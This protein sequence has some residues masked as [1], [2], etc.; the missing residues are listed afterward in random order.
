MAAMD[1]LPRGVPFPSITCLGS[2]L[3]FMFCLPIIRCYSFIW[4]PSC[5][6]NV[7]VGLLVIF[8]FLIWGL[9]ALIG[10]PSPERL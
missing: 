3:D 8:L 2:L 10:M 5:V 7:S 9:A 4:P 6:A 1:A